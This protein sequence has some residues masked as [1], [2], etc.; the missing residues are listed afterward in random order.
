MSSAVVQWDMRGFEI[1][2]VAEQSVSAAA[3]S[4]AQRFASVASAEIGCV[5]VSPVAAVVPVM[6]DRLAVKQCLV[7]VGMLVAT[8]AAAAAVEV[9]MAAAAAVGVDMAAVVAAAAVSAGLEV[10]AAA[11]SVAAPEEQT[12]HF[13]AGS[14]VH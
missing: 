11:A 3:E 10:A 14:V 6:A 2:T 5:P 12:E 4:A 13:A 8:D 7:G 1:H 9:D